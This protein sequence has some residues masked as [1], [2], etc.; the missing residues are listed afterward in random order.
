MV[1]A[2]SG[3]ISP[4]S[5]FFAGSAITLVFLGLQELIVEFH[6]NEKVRLT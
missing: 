2:V 5:V 1:Y 3:E 4:H 6:N